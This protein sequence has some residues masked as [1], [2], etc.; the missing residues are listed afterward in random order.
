MKVS[1]ES[2]VKSMAE[3]MGFTKEQT[4]ENMAYLTTTN[5][6]INAD[7]DNRD[8]AQNLLL[9]IKAHEKELQAKGYHKHLEQI[10]FRTAKEVW[11]KSA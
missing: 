4:E 9:Q 2:K 10:D 6:I 3:D 8:E 5:T 11:Y 7:S 1:N